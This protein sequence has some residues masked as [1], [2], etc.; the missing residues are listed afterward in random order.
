MSRGREQE[1]PESHSESGTPTAYPR[2]RLGRRPGKS[3]WGRA[4]APRSPGAREGLS[5][6][7]KMLGAEG[8]GADSSRRGDGSGVGEPLL[9]VGGECAF[10]RL[11]TKLTQ[12][13]PGPLVCGERPNLGARRTEE[14]PPLS[15]GRVSGFPFENKAIRQNCFVALFRDREVITCKKHL[16]NQVL[17]NEH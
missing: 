8:V 13:A 10:I 17:V 3:G 1:V 12:S 9:A 15:L 5:P 11:T 14:I 7:R 6:G 16:L 2:A 4:L